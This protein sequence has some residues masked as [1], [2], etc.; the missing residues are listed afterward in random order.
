[1]KSKGKYSQ[2]IISWLLIAVLA[3]PMALIIGCDDD[4]DN[5]TGPVATSSWQQQDLV[6]EGNKLRAVEF[7]SPTKGWAAGEEGVVLFTD[8]G[9]DSWEIQDPATADNIFAIKFI[10]SLN[11]WAVGASG[12]MIR[13]IDGG[14][15]W[16]Q[17][18]SGTLFDIH[19]VAFVSASRGWACAEVG[20]VLESIDGGIT[21]SEVFNPATGTLW[22]MSFADS[23]GITVGADGTIMR[24]VNDGSWGNWTLVNSPT[25][26]TLRRVQ[27]VDDTI[28]Y[29][30][31]TGGTVIK[32]IDGGL[33][34]SVQT[35]PVSVTLKGLSFL[36]ANTGL[37]V[38]DN[39][40][41]IVT[42]DGGTTWQVGS[43]SDV[44]DALWD[45]DWV[46]SQAG[47][48]VGQFSILFTP[49]NV[50]T[51]QHY[52]SQTTSLPTFTGMHFVDDTT[53]YV[54]GWKGT[55]LKTT[56]GGET[57]SYRRQT[58]DTWFSEVYFA[59]TDSGWACGGTTE[60]VIARTT[61]GGATWSSVRFPMHDW[62]H[63]VDFID[64]AT[65]YAVGGPFNE[66]SPS[67]AFF[68]S[69]GGEVWA[70]LT[71]PPDTDADTLDLRGLDV[72]N[73]TLYVCGGGGLVWSTSDDGTSW[74]N[75]SLDTVLALN[76]IVFSDVDNGIAV[77]DNGL[78]VSTSDGGATW[79]VV[80]TPT[81]EQLRRIAMA[82]A[83]N[84]WVV[85]GN[86]TIIASTNGGASWSIQPTA[87]AE[88]LLGIDMINTNVGWIAGGEG[89][90]LKTTSGGR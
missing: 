2:G 31:G 16:E 48:V 57:W 36:D 73:G 80:S 3:M 60:G 77:G 83:S 20:Q 51:W 18:S 56:N 5:G 82:D 9:G 59:S 71:L 53:G 7:L 66:E 89:T 30:V 26:E 79:T 39:G 17:S 28:G 54:C 1:M 19:D 34:W 38:G 14:Q 63:S 27:M 62:I 8:D 33:S 84:I 12:A 69:N 32:T 81:T 22:G 85:G 68:T 88:S 42:T 10:D 64:N 11:G 50:N 72:I 87:Q 75:M 65:G 46:A 47:W 52:Y 55:V 13:T 61:D 70:P 4:D 90:I 25:L 24:V 37:A 15:D 86:G 44:D 29:A 43:P 67:S 41:V 6:T 35:T 78:L 49:G 76:D 58:V 23:V 74:T 40:T 45:V 21:W